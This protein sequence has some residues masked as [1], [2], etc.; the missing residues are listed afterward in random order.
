MT[1]R[2]LNIA[3]IQ[4]ILCFV[5]GLLIAGNLAAQKNNFDQILTK[6]SSAYTSL[7]YKA[8]ITFEEYR[9]GKLKNKYIDETIIMSPE[10][11]WVRRLFPLKAF[12][13]DKYFANKEYV[14]VGNLYYE[15]VIGLDSVNVMFRRPAVGVLANADDMVL[16]KKN[17]YIK[18]VNEEK[19][20]NRIVN[21]VKIFP[22]PRDR[23]SLH[24]WVD[25]NNGFIFRIEKYD[26][27]GN[28]IYIE[29]AE[30]VE[31]NP[32]VDPG[33]FEV[34]YS[35]KL[36]RERKRDIYM[37]FSDLLQDIHEPIYV[38]KQIPPGFV[39]DKISVRKYNKTN[40]IQFYYTDGLT[41]L[42]FFQSARNRKDQ[43]FKVLR[44][45]SDGKKQVRM[46]SNKME[47]RL[48]CDLPIDAM[49]QIFKNIEI[50]KEEE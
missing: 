27:D 49:R 32:T 12:K 25:K 45:L 24:I 19:I 9:D 20:Q 26:N 18:T 43:E 29:Y 40:I 34:K 35:G 47:F 15:K 46:I 37:S 28:K 13:D 14:H 48:V 39:L 3:R 8:T 6:I 1:Y 38:P 4:L 30:N 44:N 33:L 11:R 10:K 50:L 23:S 41:D 7:T 31:F 17:Y 16:L 22:R 2:R 36:P 5:F 21:V 42:S